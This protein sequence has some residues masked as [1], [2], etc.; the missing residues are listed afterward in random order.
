MCLMCGFQP[1][2]S[3]IYFCVNSFG[4]FFFF[5]K[6]FFFNSL[7]FFLSALFFVSKILSNIHVQE[8]SLNAYL[9]THIKQRMSHTMLHLKHVH[10]KIP[11]LY[12]HTHHR[13]TVISC[14][15]HG[16]ALST[17]VTLI[18]YLLPSSSCQFICFCSPFICR[19]GHFDSVFNLALINYLRPSGTP[20]TR[21]WFLVEIRSKLWMCILLGGYRCIIWRNSACPLRKMIHISQRHRQRWEMMDFC[22]MG[23]FIPPN[24]VFTQDWS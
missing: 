11:F 5:S 23:P 8:L 17:S 24:G 1:N 14:L 2:D 15:A 16:C 6:S 21:Y 3:T 20:S 13:I 4:A 22:W 7:T 12:A 19:P 10:V 9:H 18:A